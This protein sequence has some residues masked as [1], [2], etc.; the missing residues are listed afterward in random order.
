MKTYLFNISHIPDI[1]GVI[2][3]DD[4]D[5]EV[6]FV[7]GDG[8]GVRVP[9]IGRVGGHVRDRQAFGHV[10]AEIRKG[11]GGRRKRYLI[12]PFFILFFYITMLIIV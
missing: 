3:V 4:G 8:G 5:F 10:H 9:C 6:L 2:I 1:D 7:V 11:G 12:S